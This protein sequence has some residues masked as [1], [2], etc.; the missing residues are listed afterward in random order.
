[1]GQGNFAAISGVQAVLYIL[2]T[3]E[4]YF[5]AMLLL[6]KAWIAFLIAL[7][8][9]T[10]ISLLPFVKPIMSEPLALWLLTSLALAVAI[11]ITT[12]HRR[13]L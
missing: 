10:N 4:I 1:M 3:V 13:A 9:G 11:F 12:L 7:L 6:R 8:V 2:A 5:L